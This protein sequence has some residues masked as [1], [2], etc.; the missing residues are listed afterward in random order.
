MKKLEQLKS[1]FGKYE[2][3][4][5]ENVPVEKMTEAEKIYEKNFL[6]YK[7]IRSVSINV[8]DNLSESVEMNCK[9]FMCSLGLEMEDDYVK[10]LKMGMNA[11]AA[12]TA[13]NNKNV[14]KN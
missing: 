2:E 12:S 9:T 13:D 8:I 1:L 7:K 5:I 14:K 4:G 3:S 11:A 10:K 6:N